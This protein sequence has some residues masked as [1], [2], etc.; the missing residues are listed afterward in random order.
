MIKNHLKIAWR[1]L[2]KNR[3]SSFINIGG[4]AAGM[5]VAMLIGLWIY[6][7]LSFNKSFPNYD[8]IAQV[9]MRRTQFGQIDVNKGMPIPLGTE[10][11]SGYRGD[12]KYVVMSTRTEDYIIAAGDKIFT[13]PGRYMQPEAPEIFSLKMRAGSRRS[14]LTDPHSI[15]LSAS[16]AK[17]MFGNAD[18][19]GKILKIDSKLDVKV[20]GVYEDLSHNTEFSDLAFIMPWDL[21]IAS[22]DWYRTRQVDWM[23]NFLVLYTQLA[24]GVD[25]E[26]VSADIRDIKLNH[27]SREQAA[28]KPAAFLHPM[29][30]WHLYN[31]FENGV[32]ATSQPLQSIWLFG[33]IG[34][35]VLLLACINFMNLSTARAE[36][37]AKEVGIRKTIGSMRSQLILQFFTESILV[38]AFAFALAICL[39]LLIL[40]WF[41]KVADKH[42]ALLWEYPLFWLLGMG[43]TFITGMIAG[44][45]PALYLSSF[46]AVKVLKGTFKAGRLASLPRKV[47]VV[48]QFTVSVT[49]IIG[50]IIV[51]RQIGFSKDRPAGYSREGLIYINMRTDDIHKHYDAF[52]KDLLR[53]GAVAEMAE[54]NGTI[55]ELW[56]NNGGFSWKGKNPN[57][58]DKIFFG[59]IGVSREFGRTVGW[60][61]TGGRDFSR[62]SAGDSDAYVI[63][64]A[65]VRY[66]GLKNP[67]GETIQ[68]DGKNFR[69]IGVIGDVLMESPY[70]PVTPTFFFLGTWYHATVS[71]KINPGTSAADALYKIE[72]VFKRYAPGM[73]FNYQFA[74][75]D[76][77]AKFRAEERIGK[78][79]AFFAVLAILI[80]CLGLF[81]LS[82][83]VASQR[84]KEIGVR[85]VLG[86]SVPQLWRL[87]SRDFVMLVGISLLLAMPA[88]Y[89][90]MQGWLRNYQYRTELSW[91]IFAAAGIGALFI[92]LLT[93]SFQA[94]RAA[95][96]NPV[97]SLRSDV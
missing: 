7:E 89:Y 62:S 69:V 48:S 47:L 54:S 65:A 26:K 51:F 43:F 40:P 41:N 81:G 42:L 85:K 20:T 74:D 44:S 17:A 29:S 83:F 73:P 95:I 33:I 27:V 77:A 66:M 9:M 86:A 3:A 32:N 1:G 28:D 79:A 68:R 84:T 78:L 60:Q 64:E 37:R 57:I 5:A 6:D 55:N 52:H 18:P 10:L 24:P 22:S 58:A 4:L 70:Q 13:E 88:A 90:F 36:R 87:L 15:L 93:V 71:I 21:L 14:G 49:L 16:L 39:V 35:F 63:N 25:L 50:T 46:K 45:Y 38:A 97:K 56:S 19:M 80:S 72:R 76:Y 53:T 30:K 61:F 75:Q 59:T 92:T 34:V 94:I 23:D 12:F 67:V 96:A 8:R 11:R 91:W 82:S 2:V 31:K